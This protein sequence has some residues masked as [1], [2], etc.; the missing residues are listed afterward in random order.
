MDADLSSLGF[1][2]DEVD[3][4]TLSQICEHIE[5][6]ENENQVFE[7]LE[8]LSFCEDLNMG[9][10]V[11]HTSVDFDVGDF[12]TLMDSECGVKSEGKENT[13]PRFGPVVSDED[14]RKIIEDQEI[15]NTKYNTKWALNVFEKWRKQRDGGVSELHLMDAATMNYWLEGFVVEARKK[16]G[17]EYPP[18]ITSPYFMRNFETFETEGCV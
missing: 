13:T 6:I 3:D 18:K 15:R 8:N 1:L 17:S 16:D 9:A 4:I 11:D 2:T 10:A 12:L 14:L 7:G 5:H